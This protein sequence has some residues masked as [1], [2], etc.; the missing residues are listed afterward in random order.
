MK[1]KAAEEG[2]AGEEGAGHVDVDA[3]K[4]QGTRQSAGRVS[5]PSSAPAAVAAARNEG[6]SGGGTTGSRLPRKLAGSA[7][8]SLDNPRL[9]SGTR[10]DRRSSS[11][12]AGVSASA[13]K[14][15]E[16]EL[17][18]LEEALTGGGYSAL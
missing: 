11:Y 12:C 3:S 8:I 7:E 14:I 5:T 2:G 9:T 4:Q 17:L 16:P 1:A 13:F 10:Q 18:W 15:R 6:K